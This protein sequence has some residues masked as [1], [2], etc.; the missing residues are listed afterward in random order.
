MSKGCLTIIGDLNFIPI[1]QRLRVF[2][3]LLFASPAASA[4]QWLSL[5]HVS[6]AAMGNGAVMRM[7]WNGTYH[8]KSQDN[9]ESET[10][11]S[12]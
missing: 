10:L 4:M 12:F 9:S 6:T 3:G 5:P 7:G 2:L 11:G 8:T 1:C